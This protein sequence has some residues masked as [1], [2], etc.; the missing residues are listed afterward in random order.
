MEVIVFQLTGSVLEQMQAV[1]NLPVLHF[2]SLGIQFLVPDGSK[3][4]RPQVL[5]ASGLAR[6]QAQLLHFQRSL[7]SITFHVM[8][9]SAYFNDWFSR[10]RPTLVELPVSPVSALLITPWT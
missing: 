4:D 1:A 6:F 9:G 10:I 2:L 3:K 7:H 8:S 5:S